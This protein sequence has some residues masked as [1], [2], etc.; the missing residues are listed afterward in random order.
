MCRHDGENFDVE[1]GRK[2][3]TGRQKANYLPTNQL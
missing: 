2:I 3:A 1:T